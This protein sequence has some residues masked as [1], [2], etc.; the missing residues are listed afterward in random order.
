MYTVTCVLLLGTTSDGHDVT[1]G[2]QPVGDLLPT[3]SLLSD[4]G[5]IFFLPTTPLWKLIGGSFSF[6]KQTYNAF[7]EMKPFD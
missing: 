5:V 6:N 7:Y 3:P 1:T 2:E 4:S